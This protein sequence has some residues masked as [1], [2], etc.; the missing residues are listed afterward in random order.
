M[1]IKKTISIQQDVLEKGQH[2]ANEFFSG[3]FSLYIT[4]LINSDVKGVMNSG[5]HSTNQPYATSPTNDYRHKKEVS[6]A[7]DSILNME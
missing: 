1:R 4:Y 5:I 7:I 6:N 2:R 3:N